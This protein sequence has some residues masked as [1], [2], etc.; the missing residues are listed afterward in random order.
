MTEFAD[1]IRKRGTLKGRLTNFEKY[2]QGLTDVTSCNELQAIELK[3]RMQKINE[4]FLDFDQIQQCI[5]S[6]TNGDDLKHQ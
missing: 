2:I 5:E 4:V 6:L 1:L 3:L